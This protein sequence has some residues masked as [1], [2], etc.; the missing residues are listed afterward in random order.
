MEQTFK[1]GRLTVKIYPDRGTMGRKAAGEA[2]ARL[3]ELLERQ[4]E[5]HLIF[6]AAPSQQEFLEALCGEPGIDWSRI[7]AFHMDE[8]VGLPAEAPQAFGRF[9]KD[10]IFAKLPFRSVDYLDGNAEDI[11]TECARYA[12]LLE[13][14]PAD[15]V[16]MGIG[17]NNHIAFNDPHVADFNDSRAVKAV[18]L[19]AAC[20]LQQVH[21]GCFSHIGEVPAHA[22][23]LTIPALLRAPYIFCMVP[24][25]NKRQAVYHTLYSPLGEQYPSTILRTQNHAVL[26]VDRESAEMLSGMPP[27]EGSVEQ[28]FA[29]E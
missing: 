18:E 28:D 26:Y 21:D 1:A 24:G 13:R 22:L 4:P 9:L 14:F 27:A 10:R 8:Y 7:R 2:A 17:E 25:K 20:R 16:F 12:A 15:I 6:A 29:G 23:T 5:L 3:R 11:E 19:D